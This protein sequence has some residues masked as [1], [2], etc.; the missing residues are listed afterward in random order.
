VR[1]ILVDPPE[2]FRVQAGVMPPRDSISR[3]LKRLRVHSIS[4][5]RAT[6]ASFVRGPT[7]ELCGALFFAACGSE[8]TSCMVQADLRGCAHLVRT[9]CG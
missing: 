2:C 1:T 6:A 4:P 8:S 5:S 3:Y 9:L 7:A